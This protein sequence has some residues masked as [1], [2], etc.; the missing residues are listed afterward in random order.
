MTKPIAM[1]LLCCAMARHAGAQS[2]P[3]TIDDLTAPTS[4]AFVLLDVAPA[5]VE[6][7]DTPKS[8]AVNVLNRL[9]SSDGLP[10]DYAM[11]VAP[12]WLRFHPNLTFGE[13]QNPAPLQSVLQTFAV[14]VATSPLEGLSAGADLAGTRLGL[15]LRANLWS[16]RPNPWL[17]EGI[18]TLEEIN[19]RILDILAADPKANIDAERAEARAAALAIQALDSQRIGFFLAV[20]GGQVWEVPDGDTEK[21]SARRRGFW[22]TPSYRVRA[23]AS[24]SGECVASLDFIGVFRSLKDPDMDAIWDYGARLLWR[25]SRAMYLSIE[26]LQRNKPAGSDAAGLVNDTS[27]TVGIVEYRIRED[28]VVHGSFGRDFQKDTGARPLVSVMGLNV[29]FGTKAT[30][31]PVASTKEP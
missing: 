25:P 3:V 22:V 23:C 2:G 30:V 9:A 20:A 31:L 4:P 28:L 6:R 26:M 18:A 12:Y 10:K 13:Y 8:F 7:P 27:R 21:A 16:G 15:G 11:E 24:T 14:S 17:A 5:A 29:G 1:L 19:N